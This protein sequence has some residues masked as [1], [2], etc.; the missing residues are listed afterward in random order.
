MGLF[1][2]SEAMSFVVTIVVLVAISIVIIIVGKKRD[3]KK[4]PE[5]YNVDYL[6]YYDDQENYPPNNPIDGQLP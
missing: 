1:S 2:S 5:Q 4:H 6:D 3:A